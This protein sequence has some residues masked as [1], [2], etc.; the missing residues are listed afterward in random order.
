M[1]TP[2][3]I[4][5]D[6]DWMEYT[7]LLWEYQAVKDDYEAGDADIEDVY[8]VLERLKMQER[9][10]NYSTTQLLRCFYDK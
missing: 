5:L 6:F 7:T 3:N 8:E 4:Y 9:V 2:K 10:I 1:P